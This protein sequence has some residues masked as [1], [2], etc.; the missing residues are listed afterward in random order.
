MKRYEQQL[1]REGSKNL[2]IFYQSILIYID[3]SLLSI[4]LSLCLKDYV[5]SPPG[6]ILE[7]DRTTRNS[8]LLV[9]LKENK[10]GL[11]Y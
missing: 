1:Y 7:T 11:I 5:F 6:H 4:S 2:Y 10:S 3:V 8:L 9:A